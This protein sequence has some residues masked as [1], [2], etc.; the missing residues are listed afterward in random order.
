MFNAY[1]NKSYY[2]FFIYFLSLLSI[3][4]I[5]LL[6]NKTDGK[7]GF[8]QNDS[9]ITKRN[10]FIYDDF[11]AEIY[12]TIYNPTQ[13]N[14]FIAN[15]MIEN[16]LVD[17]TQNVILVIGCNTGSLSKQLQLHGFNTFAIH[18]S[19]SIIKQSLLLYPSLQCKIG[20]YENPMAYDTNTFSHIICN[21]WTIY[22]IKDKNIVFRNIYQWLLSNGYFIL[23]LVDRDLFN[24]IIPG[25]TSEILQTPQNF[26]KERITQTN[27]EFDTFHY[28]SNYQFNQMNKHDIVTITETFTDVKSNKVRQ[29]EQVLYIPPIDVILQ[30]LVLCGFTIIKHYPLPTDKNQFIYIVQKQHV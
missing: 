18:K 6:W 25:A 23:Q 12:D 13:N 15:T 11:Y 22:Q 1:Y 4:F 2:L 3:L 9:F 5:I 21:E 16:T 29:N 30:Q 26:T 14:E 8:I 10:E 19:K 27:I 28:K 17:K 7:E 20:N 24:T